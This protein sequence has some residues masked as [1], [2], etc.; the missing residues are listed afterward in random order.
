MSFGLAVK[1][2]QDW[3]TNKMTSLSQR[4][5]YSNQL[6]ATHAH[7]GHSTPAV[8]KLLLLTSVFLVVRNCGTL[9][10]YTGNTG[11]ES[12]T[13]ACEGSVLWILN[14]LLT[15]HV[16][17]VTLPLNSSYKLSFICSHITHKILWHTSVPQHILENHRSN[18][19]RLIHIHTGHFNQLSNTCYLHWLLKRIKFQLF[20]WL[21][22]SRCIDLWTR[23]STN[24]TYNLALY[25]TA[26]CE[27]M[28]LQ[29]EFMQLEVKTK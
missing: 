3:V 10:K 9:D 20:K 25:G 6:S 12:E 1:E 27:A 28:L 23:H 11:G 14:F 24:I 4:R 22:C 5:G 17:S 7:A 21:H 29:T 16:L 8:L 2:N 18:Q 19:S 13:C 26:H 15:G